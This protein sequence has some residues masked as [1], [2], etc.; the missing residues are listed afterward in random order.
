MR[1]RKIRNLLRIARA[2][3]ER[4]A[5]SRE[6]IGKILRLAKEGGLK[7][8]EKEQ[9]YRLMN[10]RPLIRADAI[11][12]LAFS[13][14]KRFGFIVRLFLKDPNKEV[15]KSA[16]KALTVLEC[17]EYAE[18]IAEML[19][20]QSAEVR[21]AAAEA[22]ARLGIKDTH[23]LIEALKDKNSEVRKAAIFA[24]SELK[25]KRSVNALGKVALEDKNVGVRV[26]AVW[27]LPEI[28]KSREAQRILIKALEDRSA[29]VRA[30]AAEGLSNWPDSIKILLERL[31]REKD[32]KVKDVIAIAIGKIGRK[33]CAKILLDLL[34]KKVCSRKAVGEALE[35]LAQKL[36]TQ[37]KLL[38]VFLAREPPLKRG[39][40]ALGIVLGVID[41]GSIE[42]V[43]KSS[44][45]KIL[46]YIEKKI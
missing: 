44:A 8:W 19:K 40:I 31:K 27:A 3:K 14:D 1:R 5:Y 9:L 35:I 15:R 39:L 30:Y 17:R 13:K 23:K 12:E 24:L 41:V 38:K 45:N 26:Y 7:K 25:D 4:H 36:D 46:K 32:D 11:E 42:K 29:E 28:G 43:V 20:D 34:S 16:I 37:N 33:E 2:L 21:A 18:E 10:D 22:L 6:N